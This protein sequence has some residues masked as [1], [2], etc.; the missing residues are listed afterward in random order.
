MSD[1]ERQVK[2]VF[3]DAEPDTRTRRQ[4]VLARLMARSPG[5]VH[6]PELCAPDCGGSEGL[7]RVR[8]LRAEGFGIEKRPKAGSSAPEYRLVMHED[9]EPKVREYEAGTLDIEGAT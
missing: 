5:W 2:S 4:R 7:R 1:A 8:E 9:N 6:G 3:P